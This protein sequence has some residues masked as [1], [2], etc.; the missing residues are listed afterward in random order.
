MTI[1]IFKYLLKIHKWLSGLNP[2]SFI[3]VMGLSSYLILIIYFPLLQ[4][5]QNDEN[6]GG[7]NFTEFTNSQAFLF[8]IVL[9]P[10]IETFIF[11]CLVIKIAHDLFRI[12]Y[13][14]SIVI[15]ALIF[16]IIHDYSVAY[17]LHGF[18]M[19]LLLAYSFAIYEKKKYS[20]FLITAIIH[21]I[22][23]SATFIYILTYN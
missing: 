23:N 7:A 3:S 2:L 22:R 9:C 1:A 21:A 14:I 20:S 17:Q 18:I 5:L 12:K 6:A 10:I 4:L 11:Q 19:G 13:S 8:L 15:S 16:G